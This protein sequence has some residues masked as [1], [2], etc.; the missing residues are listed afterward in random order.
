MGKIWGIREAC[1]E[2]S[3]NQIKKKFFGLKHILGSGKTI[4]LLE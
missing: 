1:P 3:E 2:F 4:Q